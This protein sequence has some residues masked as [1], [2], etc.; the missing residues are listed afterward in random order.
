MIQ[1]PVLKPRIETV[2]AVSEKALKLFRDNLVWD[3]LMP[4]ISGMNAPD[5]DRILPRFHKNGVNFISLT[6][7][8]RDDLE[9]A[10]AQMNLTRKQIR[11]RSDYLVFA[12]SVADIE[13]AR[14]AGKLAL[15][16]NFQETLPFGRKL[17][18]IQ[19]F[20]DLGVRQALLAY[21]NRNFVA[22]GCAEPAD[23]GLSRYGR[24]VVKE[25]NRVGM[26]VDGSH[27]GYRSTMEAM[28]ICDGPFIFSHSNPHAVRPHYRSIKDD[29][30][31]ACAET[32][33]VI[34]I[35]GV[36]YW[37]GDNDASTEAIFR[38]LDYTVELVGA[39]HVGLGFD[40][41]YDLQGLI[42]W[43]RAAPLIW[44]AYGNEWMVKHNYAAS[45]QMID[46][47]QMMIDHGYPDDAIIGILGRNWMKLADKVWK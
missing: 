46:L 7:A 34:G 10:I 28:E 21:N 5:I 19:L 44:P 2:P 42:E 33:G 18:N 41:V 26:F 39:K 43:A 23:A 1:D 12:A 35:N 15:G 31:K 36:G 40:Y 6:I 30:I 32:G 27:S 38:C 13:A 14:R 20:Y 17:D 37:V 47:V 25:M 4:W 9:G 22:D 24:E 45:E 3:N 11:E 16:F 8:S 29:Q